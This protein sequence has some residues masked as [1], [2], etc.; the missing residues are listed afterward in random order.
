[1]RLTPFISAIVFAAGQSIAVSIQAQVAQPAVPAELRTFNDAVSDATLGMDN[2]AFVALWEDDGVILLP[3]TRPIVGKKAISDFITSVTGQMGSA[4]MVRF[5]ND[6]HDGVVS[7]DWAS[8][9]C[10]EHQVAALGNGKTVD[11]WGKLIFILHRGTD[12]QWRL[13]EEMWNQASPADSSFH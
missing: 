10:I 9:W 1:M 2:A 6:C 13:R 7:G 8:E 12:G 4:R 3:S 5:T 11:G